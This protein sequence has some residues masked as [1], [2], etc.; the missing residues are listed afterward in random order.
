MRLREWIRKH[1][2]EID[3]VI[4]DYAPGVPV[5]DDERAMWVLNDEGLYLFAKRQG[6]KV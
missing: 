5:D 6:V 3:A 2:E 4:S 1:R